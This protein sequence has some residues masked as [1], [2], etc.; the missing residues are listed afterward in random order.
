MVAT[1]HWT[2][3]TSAFFNGLAGALVQVR[4]FTIC[5]KLSPLTQFD[6]QGYF[7]HRIQVL[8]RSWIVTI[9]S[10]IGSLVA[11]MATTAIMITSIF[12]TLPLV[13]Y[14]KKFN[15]LLTGALVLLLF[16]DIVNTLALCAHLRVERT[17]SLKCV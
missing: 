1:S 10:W 11:F 15:W 2:L 4:C 6:R 12:N 3:E 5:N 9:I 14:S 8:S 13:E 16:V 17:G 7:A